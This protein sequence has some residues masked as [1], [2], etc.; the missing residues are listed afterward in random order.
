MCVYIILAG[1]GLV[2]AKAN[3]RNPLWMLLAPAL[4]FVAAVI[5]LILVDPTMANVAGM[6]VGAGT[7]AAQAVFLPAPPIDW[8]S[9]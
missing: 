3:D 5:G 6:V 2:I 9:I 7:L 8:E 4:A 1:I